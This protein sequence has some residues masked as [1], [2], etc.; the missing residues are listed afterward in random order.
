MQTR[1]TRGGLRAVWMI[2]LSVVVALAMSLSA[3]LAHAA[4]AYAQFG[5]IQYPPGFDHFS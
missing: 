5:D 4:H 2:A 1:D 3:P